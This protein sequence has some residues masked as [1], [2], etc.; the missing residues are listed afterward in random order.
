MVSSL[1]PPQSLA[2]ALY[3]D[4]IHFLIYM[5][6][7]CI[8]NGV[9]AYYMHIYSNLDAYSLSVNL[10]N[11]GYTVIKNALIPTVILLDLVF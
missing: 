3:I 4:I 7:L 9:V 1:T 11:Q 6:F 5:C 10:S 8:A 2:H